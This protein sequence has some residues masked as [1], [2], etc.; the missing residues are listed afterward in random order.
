M[1]WY[2]K[3]YSRYGIVTTDGTY[4]TFLVDGSG[5]EAQFSFGD[6]TSAKLTYGAN[7]V[8][9]YDDQGN[10]V[11]PETLSLS[12][13]I[14][15]L[16]KIDWDAIYNEVD[17]DLTAD[18]ELNAD[19]TFSYFTEE[20][21]EMRIDATTGSVTEYRDGSSV[22]E[23]TVA[24]Q[25]AAIIGI[26][27]EQTIPGFNEVESIEF[28]QNGTV[29]VVIPDE[30][31]YSIISG[32]SMEIYDTSSDIFVY[33]VPVPWNY[34]ADIYLIIEEELGMSIRPDGTIVV[35]GPTG[36]LR[37]NPVTMEST[38]YDYDGKDLGKQSLAEM[39][40]SFADK[41]GAA[42]FSDGSKTFSFGQGQFVV[43]DPV[44]DIEL[45]YDG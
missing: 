42:Y 15:I 44:L 3:D 22:G 1:F 12:F 14:D 43:T 41:Y 2:L 23:Y 31:I 29:K 9:F 33:T 35:D 38:S 8:V 30:G 26:V 6:S 45:T 13:I 21:S 7:E 34:V 5:T 4:I 18:F 11:G 16:Q 28:M 39:F 10:K 25:L 37:I 17:N 24:D 20:G 19:G 32:D 27:G 40:T 36:I